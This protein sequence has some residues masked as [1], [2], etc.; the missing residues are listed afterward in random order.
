MKK[1]CCLDILTSS[2]KGNVRWQVKVGSENSKNGSG[3]SEK[4]NE[5][6][7]FEF[8]KGSKTQGQRS[9]V[10]SRKLHPKM[11]KTFIT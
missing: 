5:K 1:R 9:E 10:E 2:E 3:M 8:R 11:G 7:R 4:G 6:W